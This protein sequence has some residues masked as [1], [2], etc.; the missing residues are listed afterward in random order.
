MAYALDTPLTVNVKSKIS[1][2]NEA[3]EVKEFLDIEKYLE[4]ERL[5]NLEGMFDEDDD[6]DYR[7]EE[8]FGKGT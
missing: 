6:E 2:P 1:L 5:E 7:E 4:S 8:E 3:I